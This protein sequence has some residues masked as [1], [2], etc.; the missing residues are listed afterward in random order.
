MGLDQWMSAE[1]ASSVFPPTGVRRI[2]GGPSIVPAGLTANASNPCPLLAI[3]RGLAST[4]SRRNRSICDHVM[5]G[6]AECILLLGERARSSFKSPS[7]ACDRSQQWIKPALISA[8]CSLEMLEFTAMFSRV[9]V[10]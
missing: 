4:E 7:P 6:S 2:R 10:L 8:L 5:S 1:Q 3:Y 9:Y